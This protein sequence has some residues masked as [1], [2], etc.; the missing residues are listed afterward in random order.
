MSVEEF[1]QAGRVLAH[2][3]DSAEVQ[4][5]SDFLENAKNRPET[6]QAC[7]GLLQ[8]SSPAD[9]S[10]LCAVLLYEKTKK[11]LNALGAEERLGLKRYVEGLI[12]AGFPLGTTR[13]LCQIFAFVSLAVS[14]DFI[15]EIVR[16]DTEIAFEILS[17]VPLLLGEYRFP[18]STRREF[19]QKVR[20]S[21]QFVLNLLSKALTQP[22]QCL[23]AAEVL[24]DWS[25]M[26][27][28]VLQHLPLVQA[29]LK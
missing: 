14:A 9:L 23:S 17:C 29:L 18:D 1:I 22:A 26:Q 19:A 28:P 12:F 3:C 7:L 24:K 20:K 27:L 4:K 21:S 13:K 11:E 8:P 10:L 5:A 2:S 6:W 15:E 16:F 25:Q